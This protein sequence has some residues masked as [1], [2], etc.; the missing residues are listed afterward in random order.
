MTVTIR[1]LL[2]GIGMFFL[3]I[4]EALIVVLHQPLAI[5]GYFVKL[6]PTIGKKGK[7]IVLVHGW[8][9][10]GIVMLPLKRRFEA[11]GHSVHIPNFNH[12]FAGIKKLSKMLDEYLEKNKVNNCILI[13]HS[14]G[15]VI[16]LYYFWHMNKKGRVKKIICLA[17]PLKG[18][19]TGYLVMFSKSAR[20]TLPNS[21]FIKEL[22]GKAKREKD[23]YSIYSPYDPMIPR[24]SSIIDGANNIKIKRMG[25]IGFG[26]YKKVFEKTLEIINRG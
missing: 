23:V 25:H 11:R 21:K 6:K 10:S 20:Q 16:A 4:W 13:G 3:F 14:L 1:K 17:S 5:L 24:K 22:F 2:L 8:G 19:P 18:T 9:T 7:N 12:G 26:M 15:G